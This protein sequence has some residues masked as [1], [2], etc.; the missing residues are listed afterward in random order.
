MQIDIVN[1]QNEKVGSLDLRDDAVRAREKST[2][3][4]PGSPDASELIR[5]ILSSD[6]DEGSGGRRIEVPRGKMLGGSSSINGMVYIRGNPQDYDGWESAGAQGWGYRN[7]LPY[8]RRAETRA[9][10]GD[11]Y[12]GSN[13]PLHTSYGPMNNP[14][15]SIFV[16]AAEQAGYA[17]TD[18]KSVV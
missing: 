6:P 11:D 8:F 4:K 18:R 14:L 1:Q 7:V 12:R 15:Y 2:P 16:K 3:V 17:A 13:G 9:E 5:R 10:G